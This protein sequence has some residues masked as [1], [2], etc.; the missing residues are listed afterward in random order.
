MRLNIFVGFL[1]LALFCLVPLPSQATV[2]MKLSEEDLA[3]QAGT[4]ITGTVTSVKS[5]WT[6]ERTKR[7]PQDCWS[8]SR[9]VLHTIRSCYAKKSLVKKEA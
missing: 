5:E 9:G 8:L 6:E 1:V 3:N 7:I 2:V 4:I